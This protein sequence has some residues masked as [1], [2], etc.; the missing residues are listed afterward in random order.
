MACMAPW[1]QVVS[2]DITFWHA[3]GFKGSGAAEKTMEV[4]DGYDGYRW[5]MDVQWRFFGLY[6]IIVMYP[7]NTYAQPTTLL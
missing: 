1:L 6:V 3:P 2:E 4:D 7:E 5:M